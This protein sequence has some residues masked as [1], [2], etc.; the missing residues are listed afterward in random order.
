MTPPSPPYSL[1]ECLLPMQGAREPTPIFTMGQLNFS[2]RGPI[3]TPELMASS[4]EW[5]CSKTSILSEG[6]VQQGR[7]HCDERS[8]LS[9]RERERREERQVCEP[10]GGKMVTM[11]VRAA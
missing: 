3:N 1:R 10:E 2:S 7:S 8:V 4:S 9:V 11:S 6:F 5:E